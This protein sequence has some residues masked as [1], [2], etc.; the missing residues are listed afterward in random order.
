MHIIL[1]MCGFECV[2]I[3]ATLSVFSV[4]SI[5]LFGA[6]IEIYCCVLVNPSVLLLF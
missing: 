3:C 2:K 6:V 5:L 1:I 4:S